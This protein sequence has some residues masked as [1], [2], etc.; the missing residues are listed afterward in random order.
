MDPKIAE[1]WNDALGRLKKAEG[2][3]DIGESELARSEAQ[4]AACSGQI[5]IT[6]LLRG[7]EDDRKA[8]EVATAIG[9][10]MN[11]EKTCSRPQD[12]MAKARK[13]LKWFSNLS[14][15]ENKLPFE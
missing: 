7:R 4:N 9:E 3:L 5:A 6:L 13:L 15:P 1:I 14:P 2:H 11:W 8:A 12:Y 10:I